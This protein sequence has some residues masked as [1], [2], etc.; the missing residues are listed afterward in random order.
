MKKFLTLL[1]YIKNIVNDITLP[2]TTLVGHVRSNIILIIL[3][4]ICTHDITFLLPSSI[5]LIPLLNT[6]TVSYTANCTVIS[7]VCFHLLP[8]NLLNYFYSYLHHIY[9]LV[10][11]LHII[12]YY[13]T[14]FNKFKYKPYIPTNF[15]KKICE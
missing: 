13:S 14:K 5:L 2:Y 3:T 1:Y 9:V 15:I 11:F 8:H 7:T 6:Y 10:Y 4:S 12:G